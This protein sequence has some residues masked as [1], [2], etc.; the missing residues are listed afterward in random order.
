MTT[1]YAI[2]P[3]ELDAAD[4]RI[5]NRLQ[6]GLPL[7]ASPYA[8]VAVELGLSEGELLYRLERLLESGVLSRFGPMYHA[9]RL[10]GGLTL[11]AL[12]VPERD[13]DAVVEAVNA[14][15][16]VAHNYRREHRLNM[17]F[18]LATEAPERIAQVI[19]EIEAAT[20]LPV[21]NMPKQEEFH[22][23]LHLPV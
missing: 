17:W 18:V 15:P 23:R 8:A 11:A 10:G 6:D 14:F 4:R 20:G 19:A 21:F 16:E 1:A 12:A 5:I 9:E 7:V 3:A 22:V 2:P 13:Y